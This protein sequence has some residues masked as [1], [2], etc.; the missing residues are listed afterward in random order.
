MS[1]ARTH[2]AKVAALLV[3][4]AAVGMGCLKTEKFPAE[5]LISDPR[6]E[7]RSD[8][9]LVTVHFTDGDGDVGLADSDTLP[10]FNSSSY[11]YNNVFYLPEKLVNGVWTPQ[12]LPFQYRV[13]VLTPSGQNKALE[14]EIGITLRNAFFLIPPLFAGDTVRFTVKIVDRALHESNVLTTPSV[15]L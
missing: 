3:M 9:L 10:P 2:A 6:I 13:K 12:N 8:S 4:V 15:K 5:P 11:Y 14:G 7:R 1:N